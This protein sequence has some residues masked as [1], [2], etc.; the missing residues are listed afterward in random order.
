MSRKTSTAEELRAR[1]T[2]ALMRDVGVSERMAQPFVDSI[3]GCLAGQRVY[4]PSEPRSYPVLHIRAALEAGQATHEV[5]KTFNVS[6]R[7]LVRLFPGGLP[8]PRES[9]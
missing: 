1:I 3:M 7:T 2:D 8:R 5:C 9:A 4:V 6:R